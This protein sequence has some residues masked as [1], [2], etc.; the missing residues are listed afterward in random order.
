MASKNVKTWLRYTFCT[1][2]V[3]LMNDESYDWLMA[4]WLHDTKWEEKCSEFNCE[5]SKISGNIHIRPWLRSSRRA[6]LEDRRAPPDPRFIPFPGATHYMWL[7]NTLMKFERAKNRASG[8]SY[9]KEMIAVTMFTRSRSRFQELLKLAKEAYMMEEKEKIVIKMVDESRDSGDWRQVALKNRRSLSSVITEGGLKEMLERDINQFCKAERWYS[10][11]GVPWRRGYL[12]HGTIVVMEDIDVGM[13]ASNVAMTRGDDDDDEDL[14]DDKQQGSSRSKKSVKPKGGGVTLSGLL[15]AIDG[16]AGGE[17]RIFNNKEKLDPALIRPGRA[18]IV[19]EFKN[20]SHAVYRDL[21][22]VF[23]PVVG[24]YPVTCARARDE[25]GFHSGI[26]EKAKPPLTE[27]DIE[28]LANNFASALPEGEF[29]TAQ[30]Q[31]MLMG[32]RD[33]PGEAVDAV[34]EWVAEKR[35]EKEEDERKQYVIIDTAFRSGAY[36]DVILP[37]RD[38]EDAKVKAK[39]EAEERRQRR[40]EEREE[41]KRSEREKQELRKQAE[42]K[43]HQASP[44]K[45]ECASSAEPD[46]L[47]VTPGR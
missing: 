30:V 24:E 23:Y 43:V 15:N 16:V 47:P 12:L 37:R 46:T 34:A 3:H 7:G 8:G 22:K 26:D 14:E 20:A 21:F 42:D 44:V 19:V 10:S 1:T 5:V 35:K 13:P 36:Q 27:E 32:H 29:S 18:D 39:E 9:D 40:Q 38:A 45:R 11:R 25:P 33:Y 31:G 4:Y 6:S 28:E 17:G 41:K 2:S